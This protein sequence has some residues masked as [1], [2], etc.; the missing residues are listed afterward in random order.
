MSLPERL[1]VKGS[2]LSYVNHGCCHTPGNGLGMGP[3]GLGAVVL[4]TYKA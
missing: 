4:I 2:L 3:W 1:T